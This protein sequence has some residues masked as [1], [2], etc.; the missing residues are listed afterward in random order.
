MLISRAEIPDG[1]SLHF[2]SGLGVI[3]GE[4]LGFDSSYPLDFDELLIGALGSCPGI[5]DYALKSIF[6]SSQ[7]IV[8][9]ADTI[10]HLHC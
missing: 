2:G 3:M 7:S 4:S 8:F 10:Y 9:A 1:H 6:A 5:V